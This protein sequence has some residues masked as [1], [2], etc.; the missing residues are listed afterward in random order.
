L[1]L[2]ARDEQRKE[3]E[4][5]ELEFEEQIAAKQEQGEDTLPLETELKNYRESLEEVKETPF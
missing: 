4:A 3:R 1:Y 5:K 2:K